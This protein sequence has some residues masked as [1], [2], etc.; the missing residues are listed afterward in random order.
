VALEVAGVFVFVERTFV[1]RALVEAASV[2]FVADLGK[3]ASNKGESARKLS[4]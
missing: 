2:V 4:R 1:P 3:G